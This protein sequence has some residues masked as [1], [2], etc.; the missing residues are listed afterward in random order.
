MSQAALDNE[1]TIAGARLGVFLKELLKVER[2]DEN[3]APE[4]HDV[5]YLQ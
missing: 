4:Y 2:R 1:P 3:E 5:G